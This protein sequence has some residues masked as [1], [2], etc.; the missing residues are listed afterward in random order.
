MGRMISVT[1]VNKIQL[2]Q[3]IC[4][5]ESAFAVSKPVPGDIGPSLRR[6]EDGI[7]SV[8]GV[9]PQAANQRKMIVG[10]TS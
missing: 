4:H 1:M 9:K 6:F 7:I 8:P 10:D 3:R 2:S 5:G